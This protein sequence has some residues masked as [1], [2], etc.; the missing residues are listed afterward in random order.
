MHPRYIFDMTSPHRADWLIPAGLVALSAIPTVA[1]IFRVVQIA[2][3][4]E[5]TADNARFL[6]APVPLVLHILGS[7]I[8]CVLGAFQ[9]S[10]GLRRRYPGWHRGAGRTLIPCGLLAALAGMWMAHFYAPGITPPASFDG[11]FVYAIRLIAG[12][13]MALSLCLGFAALRRRDIPRHRVWMLRGYA[14]GLGAGM[15]VVMYLPW[16]LLPGIQG[17][18]ARTV[19]MAAG[20]T[21]NL[22]VAEWSISFARQ[23]RLA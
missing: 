4:T 3:G 6:M 20:W 18:L 15:Q 17:E 16:Y 8:F 2:V 10:P 14:L 23:R 21:V 13:A 7:V 1:G 5:I 19:L 22:A 12:S 9:F 11:P